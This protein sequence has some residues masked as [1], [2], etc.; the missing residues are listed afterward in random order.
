MSL[1]P[2]SFRKTYGDMPD[3]PPADVIVPLNT[4]E[5][6]ISNST[7]CTADEALARIIDGLSKLLDEEVEQLRESPLKA[8][9]RFAD[10]KALYLLELRRL[11]RQ[12]S[13]RSFNKKMSEQIFRLREALVRNNDRLSMHLSA[14]QSMTETVKRAIQDETSDGTYAP[15][16]RNGD[17]TR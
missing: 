6:A 17:Q 12:K 3:G 4:H 2:G 14:A 11:M 16:F 7:D 13:D 9:Q 15:D 10:G 1:H 5:A 8:D